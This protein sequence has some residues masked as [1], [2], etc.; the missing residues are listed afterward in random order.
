MFGFG[1]LHLDGQSRADPRAETA[2]NATLDPL[3]L[4]EDGPAP[5]RGRRIPAF[6][7]IL[8]RELRPEEMPNGQHH[9]LEN[10]GDVGFLQQ[11]EVLAPDLLC[12]V[13]V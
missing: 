6:L 9:P 11:S 7:R 12:N 3:F 2:G 8:P 4:D 1:R 5:E 10:L 13:A